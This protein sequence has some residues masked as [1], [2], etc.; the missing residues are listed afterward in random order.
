MPRAKKISPKG[1]RLRLPPFGLTV[2]AALTSGEFAV[3]ILDENVRDIDFSAP[4]DLVGLSSFTSNVERGYEV[5]DEY[6]HRGV[7]VVMGGFHVTA[8]PG[9]ALRHA[10][11]V[12][13]GEAENVWGKVLEDFKRGAMKGIYKAECFHDLKGLPHPRLDLLPREGWYTLTQMVQTM[14]GCPHRCEF[15]STSKF[16][17]HTFRTRPIDEVVE[18]VQR[19]NR[20]ELVMFVDDDIAGV[21]EYARELFRKLIPLKISWVSQAGIGIAKDDELLDLAERSGCRFLFIGLETTDEQTLRAAHKYQNVPRQY[22]DL[23]RKI[24]DHHIVLQAGFVLGLD[25]DRKDIFQCVD[26]LAEESRVDSISLN[27]L[28]PYPGT[29]IRERL[30]HEGRVTSDE[31][32]NYVYAGV[33]YLPKRMTQQE[34]HDGYLRI[35]RKNTTLWTILKKTVRSLLAGRSAKLTAAANFGTRRSYSHALAARHAIRPPEQT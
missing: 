4:A 15:C 34:L 33:N 24:Q 35:L 31:W 21:P 7:P 3:S 1:T 30:L 12:V 18:E 25:N 19:L 9:E 26:R 29:E 10:D 8:M 6:R 17:G 5:A 23:I 20:D 11:A 14:R 32:S 28:Y 16:W 2:I 13:V 22:R 27:I